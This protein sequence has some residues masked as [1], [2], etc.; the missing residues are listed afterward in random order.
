MRIKQHVELLAPAGSLESMKAAICAGADAV[1]IGGSRFGARAFADNLDESAMK[2]AIDY[3][4]LHGVKLYLTVN[5]LM[6]EAE[7]RELYNY[8]SPFYEQGLDAVIVQDMGVL[9]WIRRQFPDLPI[10][11][12]TQMTI[13][14]K[15][16]AKLLEQ[17]GVT[18]VVTARELSLKEISEIRDTCHVEIESFVHGALCYCYSGQCLFSSMV[19]GRS[20]NRGRCAQPCR[21]PYETYINGKMTADSNSGYVLSLKDLNTLTLLP[22]IIE[23]GVMSL[24][25][26]G[27]MK[28]PEYT[29]GVVSIYRKYLDQYLQFGKENYHVRKEDMQK[30]WDL[31]NRKG[32][33]QGYYRQHNGSDMLTHTKADFRMLNEAWNQ[34]IKKNYVDV[35][36]R[37]KVTGMIVVAKNSPVTITLQCNDVM[38]VWEGAIPEESIAHSLTEEQVRRQMNRLGGSPFCW[39]R[40]DVYVDE[41]VFLPV[42]VLNE[43]RRE[44]FSQLMCAVVE[45]YHR[46]RRRPLLMEEEICSRDENH[47]L[48]RCSVKVDTKEQLEAALEEEGI[49][50]IYVDSLCVEPKCYSQV[51]KRIRERKKQGFLVMPRIMRT[52]AKHFLE[53]NETTIKNSGWDGYLIASLECLGW[54][55]RRKWQGIYVTDH[56]LYAWTKKAEQMYRQWG[57]QEI[58]LPVELT[59]KELYER[60]CAGAELIVYGRIPMMVSAQCLKKTTGVCDRRSDQIWIRDR[61]GNR[62]PVKNQCT[63]CYNTI[64][65]SK[66]LS[67]LDRREAVARLNPDSIRLEM[68]TETKKQAKEI[69][70]QFV[71]VYQKQQGMGEN[72]KEFTRG[73][74]NRK[75]D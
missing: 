30:L 53:Q 26:E 60:G 18:R 44:A 65:N 73:N 25:I 50:R 27:R 41:G 67:L 12:S 59:Q 32:F 51:V 57:C 75:V 45:P 58:T 14:G 31:F 17:A 8:L 9:S 20:G 74:F 22:E 11:A 68:T 5:T 34:E 54:M 62:M 42:S 64:Y 47:D 40:L 33:T 72:L 37:E 15:E 56:M 21:L 2:E 49:F 38:Q 1:Y 61:M 71:A 24:K 36:K 63:Y 70:R 35:E 69:L 19:G 3:A 13:T 46:S 10:H 7:L 16:S 23:A 55:R 28:K 39:E 52:Q 43:M 29:A 48:V 4:H 6:K 66:P